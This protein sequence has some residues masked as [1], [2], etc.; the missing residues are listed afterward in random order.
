MSSP[1]SNRLDQAE[2]FLIAS[3]KQ[4]Q[5]LD[6]SALKDDLSALYSNLSINDDDP[7]IIAALLSDIVCQRHYH[8][9]KSAITTIENTVTRI[10]SESKEAVSKIL[11]GS[12][13]YI[14]EEVSDQVTEPLEESRRILEQIKSER[15]QIKSEMALLSRTRIDLLWIVGVTLLGCGITLG[16]IIE[17]ASKLR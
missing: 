3:R 5:P 4:L 6:I 17:L 16:A 7:G 12:A 14:A 1:S 10:I 8:E 15:E 9:V 2:E 13:S 11:T